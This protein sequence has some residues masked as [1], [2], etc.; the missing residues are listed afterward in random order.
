M[1]KKSINRW[2]LSWIGTTK[3]KLVIVLSY[4]ELNNIKQLICQKMIFLIVDLIDRL[5]IWST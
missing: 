5:T 3:V 2:Q 1:E 4:R